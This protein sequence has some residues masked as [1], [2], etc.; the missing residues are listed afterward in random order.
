MPAHPHRNAIGSVP[1]NGPK[2]RDGLSLNCS[3]RSAHFYSERSGGMYAPV[4]DRIN[5]FVR[6]KDGSPVRGISVALSPIEM[7]L[8]ETEEVNLAELQDRSGFLADIERIITE[9]SHETE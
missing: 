3:G 7:E 6:L 5:H 1:P 2:I 4:L 9:I 8:Y